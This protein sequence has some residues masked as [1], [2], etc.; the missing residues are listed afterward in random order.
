MPSHPPQ[1]KP[2]IR[3]AS[4]LPLLNQ[5]SSGAATQTLSAPSARSPPGEA[6]VNR[7]RGSLSL[8][9][10][11]SS[12]HGSL[13]VSR[14]PSDLDTEPNSSN[15]WTIQI[16]FGYDDLSPLFGAPRDKQLKSVTKSTGTFGRQKSKL[17]CLSAKLTSKHHIPMEESDILPLLTP[18][19]NSYGGS[20][21]QPL[22][23]L[24][25]LS[26]E[27]HPHHITE[28]RIGGVHGGKSEKM[29]ANGIVMSSVNSLSS[30]CG[31]SRKLRRGTL[32]MRDK[33]GNRRVSI[34]VSLSSV[35][36]K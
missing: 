31:R 20:S 2:P 23:R 17:G 32:V 10:I 4:F 11:D 34:R 16:P 24:N 36:N 26:I 22:E 13:V 25:E 1:K 7:E 6:A 19:C 14:D 29:P 9:K 15:R 5:S 27:G 8:P 12:S 21:C 18:V 28:D 30:S 33:T 35:S 3:K